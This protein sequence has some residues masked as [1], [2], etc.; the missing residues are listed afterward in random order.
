MQL[1]EFLFGKGEYLDLPKPV[2][3]RVFQLLALTQIKYQLEED[4]GETG[5]SK[6]E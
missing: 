3:F 6:L 5:R 1:V 4:V 2:Q